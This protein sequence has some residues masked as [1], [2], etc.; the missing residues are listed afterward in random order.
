MIVSDGRV[1][2]AFPSGDLEMFYFEE[3][4]YELSYNQAGKSKQNEHE[5]SVTSIS[6]NPDRGL[7]VSG[8]TDGTVRIWDGQKKLVR[9]LVFH[10]PIS[11]VYLTETCNLLVG[12]MG[13]ISQVNGEKF[14]PRETDED[15][16]RSRSQASWYR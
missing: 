7:F 5:G 15:S 4:N 16:E 13:K 8:S 14:L 12:H 11:A 1:F 2:T 6:Y 3:E 10:E 9:E